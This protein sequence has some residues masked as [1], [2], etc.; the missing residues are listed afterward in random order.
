VSV[1][2]EVLTVV[3]VVADLRGPSGEP[4]PTLYRPLLRDPP[5]RFALL[6]RGAGD[7]LAAARATVRDRVRAELERVA[8]A[9]GPVDL[10]PLVEL[11]RVALLPQRLAA[12][13]GSLFGT[14]GLLVAAVGL[15]ALLAL[16]IAQGRRDLAVRAAL[17]ARPRALLRAV[18]GRALGL[19]ACG[20]ALG[21]AP[22]LAA[23][24][25]L[26]GSPAVG[27]VATLLVAVG[28]LLLLTT[29]VA[30]AVPALRAGRVDPALALRD[31]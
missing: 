12:G 27:A 4:R 24:G 29:A 28:G 10:L 6:V 25:I 2:Q 19:V 16:L 14:T 31:E 11:R 17:G 23:T 5:V 15:Y 20:Y 22:V 9:L 13:A 21:A 26:P 30:G 8:P 18:L 1:G 7:D 3:G